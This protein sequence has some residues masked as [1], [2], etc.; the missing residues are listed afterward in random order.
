VNGT[1]RT[2]RIAWVDVAKSL[3]IVLIVLYH[4][5]GWFFAFVFEGASHPAA[6]IWRDVSV[7]LTPMRIPLFFVVSGVLAYRAVR[8]SWRELALTRLGDLLWPFAVWTVLISPLWFVRL[9]GTGSDGLPAVL[10]A[11]AFAGAHLWF[12]TALAA[13]LL[14][15]KLTWRAPV[16][17]VLAAAALA[18]ILRAPAIGWLSAHLPPAL[19]DNV[20]RWMAFLFWFLLGCFAG[21]LV[22]WVAERPWF[23]A[24][25]GTA[26]V[27]GMTLGGTEIPA[28]Y[29]IP[30]LAFAGVAALVAWSS[31]ASRSQRLSALGGYL[32]PRTLSIYV[33]HAF[34]LEGLAVGVIAVRRVVPGID[35]GCRTVLI[36]FIP[37]LT[38]ALVW[39][40]TW[41]YDRCVRGRFAWLY[42]PPWR[43]AAVTATA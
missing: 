6:A 20:G 24:G 14:V 30:I 27:V 35:L 16:P 4:V 28:R 40:A 11:V 42:Q 43:R 41:F 34:L 1:Q 17:A 37:V 22:T 12:L 25:C 9:E 32:A 5:S 23:F 33:G 15:A 38:I 7:L 3:A 18:F 2:A 19:A 36:V 39:A 29:R 13:F 26:I 21:G 8:R 31:I 10:G